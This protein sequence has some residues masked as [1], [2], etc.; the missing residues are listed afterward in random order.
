MVTQS[1]GQLGKDWPQAQPLAS[2]FTDGV[3]HPRF[4]RP[5]RPTWVDS[6]RP[7]MVVAKR[8][9]AFEPLLYKKMI[10]SEGLMRTGGYPGGN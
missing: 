6:K 4:V 3:G 10:L 9:A 1:F 8:S 7:G 2:I 5:N